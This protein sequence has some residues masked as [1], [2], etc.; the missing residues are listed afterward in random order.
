MK[1]ALPSCQNEIKTVQGS[2]EPFPAGTQTWKSST[3]YCKFNIILEVR[4]NVIREELKGKQI[5]KEKLKNFPNHKKH[6]CLH[7]KSQVI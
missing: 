5:G 6:G 1:P 7:G 4:A 2:T 3:K